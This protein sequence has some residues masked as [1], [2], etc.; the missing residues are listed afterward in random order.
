MRILILG[1]S[2]MLGSTLFRQLSAN[3]K[4]DVYGTVRGEDLK[5]HFTSPLQSKMI[6]GLDVLN[7]DSLEKTLRELK[8]QVVINCVG[9]VK[10]L[11]DSKDPL[12]TLPLNSMLPFQLLHIAT[13]IGARV[14]HIS[15]D[16][17]FSGRQGMYRETDLPDAEDLYGRSKCIGE[18]NDYKHAITLRTSIIGHELTTHKSLV[19][20]FLSQ[21]GTTKGFRNA[22]FSGLPTI[23]M[24]H[25]IENYV[26]PRPEL[27]GLYHVSAA[28]INKYDLLKLVAEVYGKKIQINPDDQLKIDRSL[29]SERFTQDSGYKAPEWPVLINKMYESSSRG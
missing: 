8:P 9:L 22:I 20:W 14:I 15:T 24:A 2:G 25:I 13:S 6:T 17:V 26:L 12:L 23:E 10:Q 28:A 18:L 5:K 3:S 16:C 21:E 4:L 11:A 19:D 27:H 1:V 7:T 29:N